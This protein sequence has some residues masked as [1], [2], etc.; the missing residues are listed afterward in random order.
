MVNATQLAALASSLHDE[1]TSLERA[2]RYWRALG[3]Y[4]GHDVRSGVYVVQAFHAA[5]LASPNGAAALARAYIELFKST[6]EGPRSCLV[7]SELHTA[8]SR[9]M[10]SLRGDGRLEVQWILDR[11]SDD[12]SPT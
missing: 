7:D 8:L 3:E 4:Q 12:E 10:D 5:A 2:W 11:L 6:G 9:A 1:P